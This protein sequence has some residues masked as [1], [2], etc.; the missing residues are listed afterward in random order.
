MILSG[1]LKDFAL[2][3]VLQLLSQQKKSGT[4]T[5]KDGKTEAELHIS[6]GNLTGVRMGARS[7]EAEITRALVASGRIDRHELD[8][9]A[10]ISGEMGRPL[11]GTLVAKGHLTAE[12]KEDW[13]RMAAEDC[14]T[15]LFGWARGE[16]VFQSG[17]RQQEGLTSIFSLPAEFA[18]M[19]GMRRLDEWPSLKE[20]LPEPN[21]VFRRTG[22]NPDSLSGAEMMVYE[23]VDGAK[24]LTGLE[25]CLPLG[26]FRLYDAVLNLWEAGL[27]EPSQEIEPAPYR[28]DMVAEAPIAEKDTRTALVLGVCLLIFFSSFVMRYLLT[29]A[30][31]RG[32]AQGYATGVERELEKRKLETFILYHALENGQVPG[33]TRELTEM[34]AFMGSEFSASAAKSLRYLKVNEI[35]YSLD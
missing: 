10:S 32:A 33:Q 3:D 9:L 7:P 11:L 13:L 5:L 31:N 26:A 18:C 2:P 21:Q 1:N 35:D 16:Y 34:G 20:A 15:E 29:V 25:Q 8:E 12:Q 23:M 14:V 19:E 27:I 17:H 30:S 28:Y 22:N 4:L 24:D 6:Q